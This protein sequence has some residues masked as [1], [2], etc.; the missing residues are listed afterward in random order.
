MPMPATAKWPKPKNEDEFEDMAVDFLRIRWRDPH[1]MKN[2]RRGQRQDGVDIVGHPPWLKGK[3]EETAGGQCK[4]TDSLKLATVIAEVDKAKK[5]KGGLG[6]FVL[7]TAADRDSALQSE[8]RAHFRAHPAP[9]DIELVFWPD[10]VSDLSNDDQLVAKYWKGFSDTAS[11]DVGVSIPVWIDREGAREDETAECQ[12]QITLSLPA[13]GIDLD[14]S[15]LAVEL[16]RMMREG[17]GGRF[18]SGILGQVPKPI[19]G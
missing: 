5:F 17:R 1:A 7:V 16:Q 6:E 13:P 12:C 11:R 4:N 10:V 2:G 14:A 8:V 3:T 18:F 9:F 15:E 19:D